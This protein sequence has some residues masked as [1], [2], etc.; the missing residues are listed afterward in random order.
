[1]H[2]VS[3]ASGKLGAL[4]TWWQ[5]AGDSNTVAEAKWV[6]LIEFKQEDM[7]DMFEI[8]NLRAAAPAADPGNKT[9]E[10]SCQSQGQQDGQEDRMLNLAH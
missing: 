5:G 2:G 9:E 4:A 1:M 6:L 8:D 7:S 3:A 10:L